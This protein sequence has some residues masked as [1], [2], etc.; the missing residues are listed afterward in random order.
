[1]SA[2]EY[3]R[4]GILHTVATERLNDIKEN[5][6]YK[7]KH[8]FLK[9]FILYFFQTLRSFSGHPIQFQIPVG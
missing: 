9:F 5:N 7:H 2:V 1:M 6:F 4:R 8:M 3:H